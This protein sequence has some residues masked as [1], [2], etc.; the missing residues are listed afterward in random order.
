MRMSRRLALYAQGGKIKQPLYTGT[1]TVTTI[2]A[3]VY[4][5]L[6]TSG[7]LTI[8]SKGAYDFFAVGGG[9]SGGAAG[10]DSYSA[11]GGGGGGG[12]GY[13]KTWKDLAL[14]AGAVGAV[15]IGAGGIGQKGTWNGSTTGGHLTGGASALV[16]GST[17]YSAAGGKALASVYRH[18]GTDGGTGGSTAYKDGV[19]D[20]ANGVAYSYTSFTAGKGQLTNTRAFG[21]ST[22]TLYGG[23]GAG[24]PPQSAIRN[25]QISYSTGGAGGGGRGVGTAYNNTDPVAESGTANTGGGGGG[26]YHHSDTDWG[27]WSIAGSGGSGLII[28]RWPIA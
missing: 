27:G 2:G 10:N 17:T 19:S 12:S 11:P 28:V 5:Y 23:G 22:N 16:I 25:G 15:T 21:E 24:C 3:Y 8:Q 18:D 9:A 4:M 13:T 26:A 1:Y 7:T 14:S 6:L 20:G